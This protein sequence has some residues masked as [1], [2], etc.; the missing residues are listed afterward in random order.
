MS[1]P[2]Q[3]LLGILI[4][5]T[6]SGCGVT[7]VLEFDAS[8][9]AIL[10]RSPQPDERD[11]ADLKATY[12]LKTVLNLRGESPGERW[13]EEEREGVR[14]IDAEWRH[15]AVSGSQ[16]PRREELSAFFD[17]VEDPTK[18]P[19]LIHCQGGVHRTGAYSA[20]Y[21]MQY[22][23]WAPARAVYEME[24]NY[25]N[26]TTRDRSALKEWLL[27]YVP[28]SSRRLPAQQSKRERGV[29]RP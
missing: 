14:A 17:L 6:S 22:Q 7:E 11:L 3:L 27:R 13:F 26:W 15:L 10:I 21:R 9:R 29:K 25:F 2:R 19:I 8:G 4:A 1:G 18:W 16:P 20:L 28:D 5:L 23:G 12:G 24:D